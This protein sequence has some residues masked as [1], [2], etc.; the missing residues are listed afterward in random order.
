MRLPYSGAFL[1]HRLAGRERTLACLVL[2]LG[3]VFEDSV[4]LPRVWRD[5]AVREAPRSITANLFNLSPDLG[6]I[7][8]VLRDC[9]LIKFKTQAQRVR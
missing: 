1:S 5:G 6:A 4:A 9:P 2:L 7:E 3:D 8:G